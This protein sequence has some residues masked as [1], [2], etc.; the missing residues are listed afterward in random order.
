MTVFLTPE[1][2][3]GV[4]IDAQQLGVVVRHL[5]EMRHDPLRIDAVAVEAAAELVVD[6]ARR[7]SVER[8]EDH[9]AHG[10]ARRIGPALEQECDGRRVRELRLRSE[11]AVDLVE[12]GAHLRHRGFDCLLAHLSRSRLVQ[13][14]F[15]EA[16][17][18]RRLCA[19]LVAP[20]TPG[21]EDAFEDGA[22]ARPAVLPVRREVR[23]AVEHF[24][25]GC[26][27][28]GE[29]PAALARQCLH[30]AL[31]ARVHVGPLVAVHLD[32]D[33]IRI[34]EFGEGG[35]LV[36]FAIHDVAPVAP[37]GAD[38]EQHGALEPRGRV[39]GLAS[40]GVP[41]DGLM[42]GALQVRGGGGGESVRAH[43]GN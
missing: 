40:P 38:V 42:G 41:V 35:V 20:L 11:P 17:D 23:A 12:R 32:A 19:D 1:G 16:T 33:E 26:K 37:D 36:R 3:R 31:I 25:L 14:L 29:R 27:E 21:G 8:A 6:A 39:E 9:G 18:G 15:D 5:L 43:Y 28:R 34:E 7:H 30:G 4:R 2:R 24:P 22:K 10:L 13:I